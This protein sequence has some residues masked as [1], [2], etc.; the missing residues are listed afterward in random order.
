MKKNKSK[1]ATLKEAIAEL[2][3]IVTHNAKVTMNQYDNVVNGTRLN[4]LLINAIIRIV[5]LDAE[6]VRKECEILKDELLREAE[7]ASKLAEEEKTEEADEGKLS[8]SSG[9][10][11]HP[12]EAIIFGD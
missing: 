2:Q 3:Q 1:E 8:M 12:K 4:N 6:E 11:E 5:G 7:E 9:D 10:G